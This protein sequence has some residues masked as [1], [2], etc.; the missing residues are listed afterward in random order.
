MTTRQYLTWSISEERQ[1]HEWMRVRRSIIAVRM[2][3]LVVGHAVY[4]ILCGIAH[5]MGCFSQ[6]GHSFWVGLWSMALIGLALFIM[7][8]LY[9]QLSSAAPPR[10]AIRKNG[11]TRYGEDGPCAHY[12]WTRT[13]VLHIENDRRR[14]EF[15]SLILSE[16]RRFRWMRRAGRIAIPLPS[17]EHSAGGECLDETHVVDALR[18]AIEDNGMTWRTCA[19]GEIVLC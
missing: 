9:T 3:F 19:G 4:F 16:P 15:R 11:L 2:A 18:Q 6:Y 1:R 8:M 14:P 10:F 13:R 7:E 5:W 12:D 17:P